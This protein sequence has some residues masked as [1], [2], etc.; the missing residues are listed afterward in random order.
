MTSDFKLGAPQGSDEAVD[1]GTALE[2]SGLQARPSADSA[3]I[4]WQTNIPANG[5]A[6]VK[7]ASG[8]VDWS[9]PGEGIG[10]RPV[11]AEAVQ[12]SLS[13]EHSLTVYG[14]GPGKTYYF[15]AASADTLGRSVVTDEMSFKT[16]I[17]GQWAQLAR[18]SVRPV[19]RQVRCWY[20]YSPSQASIAGL[21]LI[22]FALVLLGIVLYSF[23]RRKAGRSLGQAD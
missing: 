16:P 13:T 22:G 18:F 9:L 12:H 20:R 19:Y 10:A 5:Q 14:L 8:P 6:W 11:A 7:L 21:G 2:I 3:A 17:D 1:S 23:K 4:T 15:Q